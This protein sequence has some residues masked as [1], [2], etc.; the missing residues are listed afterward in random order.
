MEHNQQDTENPLDLDMIAEMF[1]DILS[2]EAAGNLIA[3][4]FLVI[5]RADDDTAKVDAFQH[6]QAAAIVAAVKALHQGGQQ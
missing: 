2:A 6:G 5:T 1:E 3:I 4:S